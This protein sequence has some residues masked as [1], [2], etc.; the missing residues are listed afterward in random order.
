MVQI[1]LMV[2][3]LLELILLEVIY[4]MVMDLK[5]VDGEK[6]LL[7]RINIILIVEI[8]HLFILLKIVLLLIIKLMDFI[9]I[10][11]LDKLLFGII[12]EH[13]IIKLI[14]I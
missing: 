6:V 2:L 11:N 10:I 14:L 7:L 4:K 12:I 13:I 9:L 3:G 8:I 5:L 1:L